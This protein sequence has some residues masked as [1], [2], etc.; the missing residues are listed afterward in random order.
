M[1]T[2]M[3]LEQLRTY[4]GAVPEPEDFDSFWDE[5]LAQARAAGGEVVV[6]SVAT[7]KLRGIDLYDVTFP[8]FDGEPIKA[9]LRV[10]S[11]LDAP[12]PAVVQYV[13]YGGGR[14]YPAQELF[15]PAAGFVHLHMDSRGQGSG[16]TVGDTPD[17][18]PSG[19]QVP[20]VMTKGILDP[21]GYY[22]RRLITDAVRAVDAAAGLGCVDE[23]RIAVVGGSQGGA[24]ALAAG[25]LSPLV[26]AVAAHVPFLCDFQRAIGVT[27][28]RPFAE[29]TAY[30]ACH[31][32][33]EDAVFRTLS[34]IDGVNFAKRAHAPGRIAVALMD[35]VVPPST[36]FAAYNAYAA[37]KDLQI[38]RHNGHE[39]GGHL[40]DLAALDF[41]TRV[42]G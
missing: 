20:G 11:G 28:E 33:Q 42:V 12:V 41:F 8:G 17:Q 30:L 4:R 19:P 39:S 21:R 37:P 26:R 2:D 35:A 25:A 18:S 1:F 14:G 9:W 10:P 36:V 22:Y 16:W 3:P 5:T 40:D 32:D 23:S 27:N 13:G 38:W 31:R 6:E 15:Y 34:Y 29:L 7:P 24:L